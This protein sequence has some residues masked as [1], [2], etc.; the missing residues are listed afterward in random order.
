MKELTDKQVKDLLNTDKK[1]H[2][3]W[4]AFDIKD[5]DMIGVGVGRFKRS[6]TKP[7]EAE[8][9]LTVIDEYQNE[10]V[11]SILLAITYFLASKLEID[12]FTGFILSD[13]SRLIQRFRE[14]GAV[15]TRTGNEFEMRLPVYKDFNELPESNYSRII[16]PILQ[17]LKENDFC[18]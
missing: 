8:L 6:A 11:G 5:D 12:I 2:V 17:F 7:H 13:N 9:A 15:M 4:A 1:D 10:G 14:L 16:K 3:A 18:P